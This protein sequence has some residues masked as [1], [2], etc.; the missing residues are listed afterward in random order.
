MGTS[1]GPESPEEAS[2]GKALDFMKLLWRL[3]HALQTASRRMAAALGVTGPQRLA[4]RV[5]GKFPGISPGEVASVLRLHPSTVTLIVRGLERGG[6][7]GRE[8][9]PGDRRRTRLRLT[10]AGREV[11]VSASGTVE[12]ATRRTLGR[13]APAD[14]EAAARVLSALAAEL[15]AP[16]VRGPSGGSRRRG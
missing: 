15:E 14:I 10:G 9:D 5:V 6:L 3:D 7:V 16:A 2:L 13:V 4:V 11:A 12:E 8:E 1:G